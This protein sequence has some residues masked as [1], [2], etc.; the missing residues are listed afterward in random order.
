MQSRLLREGL[1]DDA[2]WSATTNY[3]IWHH[4]RP[5]SEILPMDTWAWA[6]E[7]EPPFDGLPPLPKA[8]RD[9]SL[10]RSSL[11]EKGEQ[12]EVKR[13][14]GSPDGISWLH[15][16]MEAKLSRRPVVD[17]YRKPLVLERRPPRF[18]PWFE[19]HLEY[20]TPAKV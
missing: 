13:P 20:D 19:H 14:E 11:P 18:L 17:D 5:Q 8:F 1:T 7:E 10:I 15:H 12:E 6:N 4:L 2:E 3:I 16:E 9:P